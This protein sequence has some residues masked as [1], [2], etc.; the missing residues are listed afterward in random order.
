MNAVFPILS[1]GEPTGMIFTSL[2]TISAAPGGALLHAL[3]DRQS[4]CLRIDERR[5]F[6]A[7]SKT[8]HN[9]FGKSDSRM[10]FVIRCPGAAPFYDLSPAGS[11]LPRDVGSGNAFEGETK[12]DSVVD[13]RTQLLCQNEPR[14]AGRERR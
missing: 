13:K 12:G 1:P 4:D 3:K 14:V 2:V 9:V 6:A 11:G 5:V 7:G 8:G 10:R